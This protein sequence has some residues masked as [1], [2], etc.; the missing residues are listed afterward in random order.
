MSRSKEICK[1][2]VKPRL[3]HN[4]ESHHQ[5]RFLCIVGIPAIF[6]VGQKFQH[7][8]ISFFDNSVMVK[9]TFLVIS[10]VSIPIHEPY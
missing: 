7:T 1:F 2:K 8:A 9:T 4:Y 6:C 10:V 5:I 3:D